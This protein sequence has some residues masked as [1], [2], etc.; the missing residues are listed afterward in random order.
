M[1]QF[2]SGVLWKK[3][4]FLPTVSHF[5]PSLVFGV[6]LTSSGF[7]P[8][9]MVCQGLLNGPE[10]REHVSSEVWFKNVE[11]FNLEASFFEDSFLSRDLPLR[12]RLGFGILIEPHAICTDEGICQTAEGKAWREGKNR[13]SRRK[14]EPGVLFSLDPSSLPVLHHHL[15]Q[16]RSEANPVGGWSPAAIAA[17]S[18]HVSPIFHLRKCYMEAHTRHKPTQ[19]GKRHVFCFCSFSECSKHSKAIKMCPRWC[20]IKR[21]SRHWRLKG[22]ES[23]RERR[24]ACLKVART[25]FRGGPKPWGKNILV[26]LVTHYW[27]SM[28]Y[29]TGH[30]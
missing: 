28:G 7:H 9:L 23:L 11:L 20:F 30:L 25:E 6:S 18:E 29:C 19:G 5:N 21:Q 24:W 16:V 2:C 27:F 10:A 26:L 15:W 17:T 22:V 3:R 12:P 14:Y 8:Y 4:A 13:E 1:S